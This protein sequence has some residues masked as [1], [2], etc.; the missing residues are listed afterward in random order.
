MKNFEVRVT[1]TSE[2]L[3]KLTKVYVVRSKQARHAIANVMTN[4]HKG[5]VDKIEVVEVEAY[6]KPAE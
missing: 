5:G 6:Y 1:F 2:T 4:L 3:I